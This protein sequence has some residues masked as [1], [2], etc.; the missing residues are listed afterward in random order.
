MSRPAGCT[1]DSYDT[2]GC[3]PCMC[4]PSRFTDGDGWTCPAK[5]TTDAHPLTEYDPT[6]ALRAIV[7]AGRM[8]DQSRARYCADI[9]RAALDAAEHLLPATEAVD[10]AGWEALDVVIPHVG[11]VRLAFTEDEDTGARDVSASILEGV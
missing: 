10:A 3:I 6:A 1:Y 11:T 4:V 8:S 7:E 5:R 2:N 9:A